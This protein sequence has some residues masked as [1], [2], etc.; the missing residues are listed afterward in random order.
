MENILNAIVDGILIIDKDFK[1]SFVNK[2]MLDLC[3][4][5]EGQVAGKKCH[6]FSHNC[7]LPCK[8]IALICPHNEVFSTGQSLTVTHTHIFPNSIERIFDITASPV[9]DEKGNVVQM[10]EVLKDI[11]EQKYIEERIKESE[12]KFKSLV[13]CSLVGIYLIQ[14]NVFK[15]VN[16]Q[17]AEIFGYSPEEVIEKKGPSDLTYPED[18]TIVKEN[19]RR[20][21]SGEIK[22]I[23]YNFRA[24]KKSGEVFNIEVFGAQTIYNGQPA[25]IGTLIDI[26]EKTK[27]ET[28]LK[29]RIKELEEFYDMAVG[30]ELKMRELKDDIE[31]LKKVGETGK[32]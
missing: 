1:I 22:S 13:E 2:A 18:M 32:K 19:I 4:L 27:L 6:E 21:L 16:P 14:N 9:K 25:V 29:D 31:K 5:P 15:Y 23:R 28:A 24:V 17:L 11:T 30:R 8:D 20:R 3:G 26:T 7:T 12:E 10:V